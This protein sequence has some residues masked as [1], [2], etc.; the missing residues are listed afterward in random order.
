MFGI[1]SDLKNLQ[2]KVNS[3]GV[4]LSFI[5]AKVDTIQASIDELSDRVGKVNRSCDTV[6]DLVCEILDAFEVTGTFVAQDPPATTRE[7]FNEIGKLADTEH[8]KINSIVSDRVLATAFNALAKLPPN[9][10]IAQLCEL[11]HNRN[12]TP[13]KSE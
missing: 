1:S 9:K 11:L 4:N 7:F 8:L 13:E 5:E 6:E 10:L 3:L 2:N 12:Q